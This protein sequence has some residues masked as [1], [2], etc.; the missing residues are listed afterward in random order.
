MLLP[1]RAQ[2]GGELSVTGPVHLLD[3]GAKLA[4]RF[5]ARRAGQLPPS[6]HRRRFIT[7][8]IA[9]VISRGLG[10][11][12]PGEVLQP[13]Q[14]RGLVLQRSAKLGDEL[15]ELAKPLLYGAEVNGLAFVQAGEPFIMVG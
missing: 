6:R 4:Q 9:A 13:L 5:L 1:A 14:H 11:D 15:R 8:P 2:R 3:P 7:V 10:R 12:P